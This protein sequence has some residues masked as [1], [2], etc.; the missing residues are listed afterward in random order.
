MEG[1]AALGRIDGPMT[2][3]PFG[4]LRFLGGTDEGHCGAVSRGGTSG[5][6]VRAGFFG[7]ASGGGGDGSAAAVLTGRQVGGM[8]FGAIV[9]SA[10]FAG[11]ASGGGDGSPT[12]V[13]TR[14]E[15]GGIGFGA[16]AMASVVLLSVKSV[17]SAR[18]MRSRDS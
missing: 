11:V 17:R 8:G 13:L 10:G 12:A 18:K 14:R 15:V 1:C 2:M 9:V 4:I 3:W 16:I 7:A 6:V 5:V